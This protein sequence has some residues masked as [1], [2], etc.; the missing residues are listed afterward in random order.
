MATARSFARYPDFPSSVPIATIPVVSLQKLQSGDEDESKRLF[1]ASRE[2]GFFSLSL[3]GSAKGE[4]L[5]LDVEKMFDL[6]ESTMNLGSDILDLYAYK[7][8]HSLFGYKRSGLLKTDDGKVDD[9]AMYNLGQDDI[10]GNTGRR[11]NPETLESERETCRTFFDHAYGV[12]SIALAELDKNLGL[13][14]G[15]LAGLC[16]LDKSSETQLRMLRSEPKAGVIDYRRITLGGHT[17]IGAITLLFH[18][19]GGLQ[20]LPAGSSNVPE[21]WQ[22]IRPQPNCALINIGDTLVEWSGGV[23]RS[24]LHRVVAAPGKQAKV[25]RQSL[26]YL[27][28]PER[29]GS[30]R[31]LKSKVIPELDDGEEEEARTVDEWA[32]WRARQV[33]NGELKPETRGGIPTKTIA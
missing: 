25:P 2:Y 29:S 7:P 12:V 9:M 3:S 16:P 26:A 31:R 1:Q 5:L 18:T 6:T 15:T 17:D 10:M 24:S 14:P 11:S 22:Y 30:M 8:P 33:M 28:R 32:A 13:S 4:E 19:T 27:L 20:I 23:L 21:N